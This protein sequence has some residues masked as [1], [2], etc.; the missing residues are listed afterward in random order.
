[1]SKLFNKKNFETLIETIDNY[2]PEW[3]E[4]NFDILDDQ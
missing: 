1:M 3:I 2:G 4:S